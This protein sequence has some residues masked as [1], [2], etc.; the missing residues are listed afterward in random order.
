MEMF[1]VGPALGPQIMAE[2]GDVRRFHSK[3]LLWLTPVLTL[4]PMTP[5]TLQA[6][7]TA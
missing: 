6:D 4:R 5:A 7:T 2:I 1:G 3:K